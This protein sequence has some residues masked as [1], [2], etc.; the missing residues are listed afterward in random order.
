MRKD[1]AYR[2]VFGDPYSIAIRK[3]FERDMDLTEY[4]NKPWHYKR[5]KRCGQLIK[6]ILEVREQSI[7]WK[8]Q[9]GMFMTTTLIGKKLRME[10]YLI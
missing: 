4:R 2:L 5:C 1:N 3:Q 10:P 8:C 6:E 7:L 9:C